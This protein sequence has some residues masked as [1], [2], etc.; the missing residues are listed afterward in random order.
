MYFSLVLNLGNMIFDITR[1]RLCWILSVLRR[2]IRERDYYESF[3][4]CR[5]CE[6]REVILWEF[7]GNR[8]DSWLPLEAHNKHHFALNIISIEFYILITIYCWSTVKNSYLCLCVILE[9]SRFVCYTEPHNSCWE[10]NPLTTSN[11]HT[12]LHLQL[13]RIHPR[14]T[15]GISLLR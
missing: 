4:P 15:I 11:L 2:R 3:R 9:L 8:L 13:K 1:C 10:Q 6:I 14:I 7:S 12:C 5:S